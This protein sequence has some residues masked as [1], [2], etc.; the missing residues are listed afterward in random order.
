M[1]IHHAGGLIEK[2]EKVVEQGEELVVR[3]AMP[4]FVATKQARGDNCHEILLARN[5]EGSYGSSP[6]QLVPE[7]KRLNEVRQDQGHTSSKLPDPP[8]CWQVV[9]EE[10][11]PSFS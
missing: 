10:G 4:I 8:N 9:A 11:D 1:T 3:F 5:V 6:F 2:W 7:G